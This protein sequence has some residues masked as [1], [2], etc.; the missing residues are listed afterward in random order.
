MAENKKGNISDLGQ[1]RAAHAWKCVEQGCNSDYT[2]LAKS[3]PALIMS[4]GLMPTLAFYAAKKG[5]HHAKLLRH[6][7]TWLTQRFS[8]IQQADFAGTIRFLHSAHSSDYR[9][10][11]EESLELLRWIRQFAPAV[12]GDTTEP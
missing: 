2:N 4:N 5:D 11:T 9:R 3:A 6:I 12:S 10:A 8:G 7:M 1:R